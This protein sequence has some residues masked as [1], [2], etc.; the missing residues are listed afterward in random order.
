MPGPAM[1]ARCATRSSAPRSWRAGATLDA[2]D[3]ALAPAAAEDPPPDIADE[4]LNLDALE[5]RAIERALQKHK[6]NVSHAA[7]ELGL[8]R[9]SLYRRMERHGL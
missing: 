4:T 2:G 7:A 3:F 8:T 5:K 6:G 9:A 1:C